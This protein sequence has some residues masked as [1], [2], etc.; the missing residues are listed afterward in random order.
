[1]QQRKAITSFMSMSQT[2]F[3]KVTS[4]ITESM[5]DN[6]NFPNPEPNMQEIQEAFNA[7]MLAYEKSL[8]GTREDTQIKYEKRDAFTTLLNKLA[9]YVND[10]AKGN[11]ALLESSGFNISAERHKKKTPPAPAEVK[12]LEGEREGQI[13]IKHPKIKDAEGYLVLMTD[14]NPQPENTQ[15]WTQRIS[16]DTKTTFNGLESGKRYYF[17]VA[18]IN[19][20]ANS[21]GEYNFSQTIS[22]ISQ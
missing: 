2:E 16:N 22:R 6:A 1:M 12:S 8:N 17:K 18:G 9:Q 13:I 5:Q 19:S 15:A 21:T 20:Y 4:R 11:M 7:Y 10:T 3:I 14:A